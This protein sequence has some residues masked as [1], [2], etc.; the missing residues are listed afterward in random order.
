MDAYIIT[1]TQ[2][3]LMAPFGRIEHALNSYRPQCGPLGQDTSFPL[4]SSLA[5]TPGMELLGVPL[6]RIRHLSF[7][8]WL[9]VA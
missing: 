5:Q 4:P 1:E 3:N 6:D 7:F 9:G 8:S 2:E